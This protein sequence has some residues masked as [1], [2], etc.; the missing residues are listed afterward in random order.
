MLI[1]ALLLMIYV[2]IVI[3]DNKDITRRRIYDI[4]HVFD[5]L[6]LVTRVSYRDYGWNGMKTMQQYLTE[7]Y[8]IP[9][10]SLVH[11]KL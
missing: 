2:R 11:S 5:C 3:I 4:I 8:G 10:Y 1:L 7:L 9:V 6:K